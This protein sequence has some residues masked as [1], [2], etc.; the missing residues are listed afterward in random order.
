MRSHCRAL[1]SIM[2]GVGNCPRTVRK[3][4]MVS[5]A[6]AKRHHV[7]VHGSSSVSATLRAMGRRPHSTA[8]RKARR[9]PSFQLRRE[10]EEIVMVQCSMFVGCDTQNAPWFVMIIKGDNLDSEQHC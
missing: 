1:P 8:V 10:A 5:M 9:R 3:K 4:A 2:R 7:I 6:P